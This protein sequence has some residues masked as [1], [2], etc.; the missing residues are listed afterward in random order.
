MPNADEEIRAIATELREHAGQ[1]VTAIS[2]KSRTLASRLSADHPAEAQVAQDI[3]VLARDLV[4]DHV[5][6]AQRLLALA[7]Q[8]DAELGAISRPL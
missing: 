2:M 3:E 4:A 1:V 5:R 8:T 7:T 6:L